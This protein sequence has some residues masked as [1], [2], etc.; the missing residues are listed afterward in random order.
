MAAIHVAA[1][2][3]HFQALEMLVT[4][5]ADINAITPRRYTALHIAARNEH[6][7]LVQYLIKSKADLNAKDESGQT[8]LMGSSP[9]IHIILLK[10]GADPNIPGYD[11]N[12]AL[13]YACY[14]GWVDVVQ[15]LIACGADVN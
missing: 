3:G 8:P 13:H 7:R 10:A 2:H 9:A 14:Y 6:S 11:V 1:D 12:T 15:Q 4:H 5:G